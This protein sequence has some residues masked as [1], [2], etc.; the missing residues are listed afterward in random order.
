[1]IVRRNGNNNN[2]NNNNLTEY[3][4]L[5]LQFSLISQRQSKNPEKE[6]EIYSCSGKLGFAVKR[7]SL[8]HKSVFVIH[9]ILPMHDGKRAL[10]ICSF[11][12]PGLWRIYNTFMA[13]T[14]VAFRLALA[15]IFCSHFV[16]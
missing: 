6:C 12:V 7:G 13:T 15:R 11:R 10:L 16:E 5:V 8:T 2:N 3:K 1:M 9:K 14:T 4:M